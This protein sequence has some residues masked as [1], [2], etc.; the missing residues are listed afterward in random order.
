MSSFEPT[1]ESLDVTLPPRPFLAPLNKRTQGPAYNPTA[2][3]APAFNVGLMSG[4][5]GLFVSAVKNSLDVHNKGAMGVFT[6]TGWIAGYF[7]K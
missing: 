6:R 3:F 4:G 5:V 7:G 1:R 2:P